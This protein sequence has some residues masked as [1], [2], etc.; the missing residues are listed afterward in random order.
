MHALLSTSGSST[1]PCFRSAESGERV[2]MHYEGAMKTIRGAPLPNPPAPVS[3]SLADLIFRPT[4]PPDETDALLLGTLGTRPLD[5]SIGRFRCTVLDLVDRFAAAGLRRGDTVCLARLPRTS[6]AVVSVAYAALTCAGIRVLMPMYL[7]MDA[8][9]DW[10]RVS[11]ASAVLW[12]AREVADFGTREDVVHLSALE[13]QC[14]TMGV[15]TLCLWDELGL[16][17]LLE[18]AGDVASPAADDA[19]VLRLRGSTGP[20]AECLILTTSGTSGRSKLVRYRQDAFLRSCASWDAAGLFRPE[21]LGGRALCLLLAHSMGIRAF[22]NAV[23][24][25]QALCLIPPEWFLEHPERVASLLEHMRP[26]HVTG[27]PA[28]FRTLLEFVRYFPHLKTSLTRHLRCAVSSGAPFDDEM[29]ERWEAALGVRLENAFGTTE[30]QQVLSTLVTGPFARGLGNPLPGVELR[31][32]PLQADGSSGPYRLQVRSPFGCSGTLGEGDAEPAAAP[33]WYD[34]GD[35]V[36]LSCDGLRH[37]G[38]EGDDFIKDGFGVKLPRTLLQRRYAG[39]GTPVEHLELFP[40]RD[41]PGLAALVFVDPGDLRPD[42]FPA[43]DPAAN[44]T[45]RVGALLEARHERL[46]AELDDMEL[47]HLTITRFA[48]IAG[49]PPRTTKGTVAVAGLRQLHADTIRDLMNPWVRRPGLV[50]LD[51][52]RRHQP[53]TVRLVR[54]LLGELLRAARLDKQFERGL[55]DRLRYRER[56]VEHEVVDFVGGFGSNLLGHRHPEVVDAARRFVDG[57]RVF[58]CDQGSAR[59]HEGELAHRLA[60]AVSRETGGSYAVRFGSTGAEAVEMAI[61]HAYMEQCERVRRFVRDQKLRFGRRYPQRVAEIARGAEEWLRSERPVVLTLAGGFHGHTLGARSLLGHASRHSRFRPLMGLEQLQLP[62]DGEVDLEAVVA[63]KEVRLPALIVDD[64]AV[65]DSEI[66]FSRIIAGIAEPVLGEGGITLADPEL[67]RRLGRFAFPLILDEIQSGLGRT[68][69]FLASAGVTGHY[70]LFGKALGG[71]VAKISALLIDRAR[72]LPRFD[73]HYSSTFAGDGFSCAVASRVLEVIDRDDVPARAA[74]RGEVLRERLE[75]LRHV[76]PA[77]IRGIRGRGLMLGLELDPASVEGSFLLRMVAEREHLGLLASAYLLNRHGVRV[78]P[79]LSAPNTLRLEPSA[80]LDDAAITRLVRGLACFCDAV[81]RL[82]TY[83]LVSFLVE[84]ELEID[85]SVPCKRPMVAFS[86]RIEAPAPGAVRVAFLNH[87]T[88]PEREIAF[89]EPG[90]R[91]LPTSARG[92]LF[93]RT[94]ALMDMEHTVAFARN[95][96]GGR[97][98]FASLVLPVD[99]ATLEQMHR[100]GE[101]LRVVGRIQEA[102]ERAAA[103]GCTVAGLGAY[104]SIVT[105]NG[106]SVMAPPG[107]RLTTGNA[108]TAAIGVRRVLRICERKRIDPDARATRLAIVGATG[109]IGSMLAREFLSGVNPFRRLT[110]L[111]RNAERLQRLRDALLEEWER[112]NP[113]ALRERPEIAVATDPRCLRGCNVIVS[114]ASTS[115]LLI[116]PHHLASDRPVLIADLSV[117]GVVSADAR[118]LPNVRIVPLAGTAT[119]PGAPDFAMSPA[120]AAGAAY[121]CAAEAMLLALE[122]EATEGLQLTGAV[123]VRSVRLLDRLAEDNGMLS[124]RSGPARTR[125]TA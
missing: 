27:G 2:P 92:A 53:D 110:L 14:R 114:A 12:S 98:W 111:G 25:R 29:S 83:E 79:T 66:R 109:N 13:R 65:V 44:A 106:T 6:E 20:E 108:L 118:A 75:E 16:P 70:Y 11:A 117:P 50:Q 57:D 39:L 42:A 82:D 68:G 102:L 89:A 73:S 33:E 80:Y 40:I 7:E 100:S 71:G 22:W 96:F 54:P 112:E 113:A 78:L 69:R 48:C 74:R 76:H 52:E 77:V 63:G 121:S 67:L 18:A 103:M 23:A 26:Q 28:V 60:L 36:E 47:R 72:Y 38:R 101:R 107:L 24:T 34:T 85:R 88:S 15:P 62:A 10:L 95:L 124:R 90:L 123:E 19:R 51:R 61:A 94:A 125:T 86:S 120:I 17:G 49:L 105:D 99:A 64:E 115:E 58:L 32:Q 21:A 45:D 4:L 31:L 59:E 8:L 84:E 3:G 41:E 43:P 97:I 122:P 93:Q 1:N 9:G 87:F 46:R 104:T 5:V 116:Y 91:R 119:V 56:G 30:T 35:L 81:R 37:A 55:G